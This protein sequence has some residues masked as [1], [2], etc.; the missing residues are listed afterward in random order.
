[1]REKKPRE[2]HRNLE[3]LSVQLLGVLYLTP[4]IDLPE[5]AADGDPKARV[6]PQGWI[7]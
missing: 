4:D 1:M 5:P 6:Y 7:V 3:R 2:L